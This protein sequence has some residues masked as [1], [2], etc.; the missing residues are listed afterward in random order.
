MK[1]LPIPTGKHVFIHYEGAIREAIYLRTTLSDSKICGSSPNVYLT[2]NI[3]GVEDEVEGCFSNF[4]EIYFSL[5]DAE[6]C[7]NAIVIENVEIDHY[8]KFAENFWLNK[9][10]SPISWVWCKTHPEVR[11]ICCDYSCKFVFEDNKLF[12]IDKKTGKR[13]N[14][15]RWFK[16]ENECRANNRAEVVTF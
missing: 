16:T 11:R 12:I 1:Y 15:K 4:G 14:S 6:E 10:C 5:A 8:N 9:Y 2:F 13:L 7:R 3:A